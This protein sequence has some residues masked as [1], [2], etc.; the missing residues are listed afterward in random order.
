M[1]G[2]KTEKPTEHRLQKAR[3]EG[4]VAKSMDLNGAVVLT[5]VTLVLL[6][7]GG[8]YLSQTLSGMLQK[9]IEQIAR[10]MASL[11]ADVLFRDLWTSGLWTLVLLTTP[12][13]GLALIAGLAVNLFQV[14]PMVSTKPLVPNLDKI[15]PIKGFKKFWGIRPWVDAAKSLLKM[16]AIGIT[17]GVII[18]MNQNELVVVNPHGIKVPIEVVMRVAGQVAFWSCGWFLVL[19][20]ADWRWQKFQHEKGL[21]MSKQDIRDERKN[22]DGDQQMKGRQ[23]QA[24]SAILRRKQ[25]AEIPNADVIVTNPTHF[26][27]ALQYDPDVAPAPRVLCKGVDHMALKIREIAAANGVPTVENKP[28]ARSLHAT[29]D[30]GHMIPPELFVAVAEVLAL[31]FSKSGGRRKRRPVTGGQV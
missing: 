21:R 15:N 5:V 28:L 7:G 19:G 20:V 17:A 6:W 18:L 13:L 2:E 14:R 25:L 23:R 22:L 3:E 1:S 27:V 30:A 4:Q 24:G 16:A 8:A 10:P 9:M 12:I 31:V 26:A 29:V 11:P